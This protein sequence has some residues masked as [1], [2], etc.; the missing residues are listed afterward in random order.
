MN[1]LESV[2]DL[3]ARTGEVLGTS[4]WMTITQEQ[5]NTFAAA[6]G[7]DQWI[8]V[9]P[10]KA[11]S[12]PFGTTIAHGLMTLA[13]VPG[14]TREMWQINGVKMILNYGVNKVRYP[15]PVRAGSRVRVHVSLV[16]VEPVADGGAWQATISATV[17]IEG[18]AKPA[19]VSEIVVR[20]V[21]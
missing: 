8:H 14:L 3:A 1:T 11:A 13:L 20:L 19:V 9:D 2:E 6:T 4:D 10:E 21:S 17:E 7:D 5:I 16:G 18:G 12:G 15:A